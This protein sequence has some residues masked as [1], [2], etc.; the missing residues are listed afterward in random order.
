MDSCA[1]SYHS[2]GNKLFQRIGSSCV[3]GDGT[4]GGTSSG[5]TAENEHSP[6]VVIGDMHQQHFVNK[7]S[8]NPGLCSFSPLLLFLYLFTVNL[9]VPVGLVSIIEY[10]YYLHLVFSPR[11]VFDMM[12]QARKIWPTWSIR[13][14]RLEGSLELVNVM[15]NV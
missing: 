11:F 14:I 9:F 3:C 15:F 6:M 4:G 8:N 10:C 12:E 13:Y 5:T 1:H 7:Q 2:G